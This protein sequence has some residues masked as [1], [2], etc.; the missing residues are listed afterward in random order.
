VLDDEVE[1]TGEGTMPQARAA[2][3]RLE[4]DVV[5]RPDWHN[6]L[7]QISLDIKSQLDKAADDRSRNIILRRLRRALTPEG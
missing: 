4:P 1:L 2:P 6:E 5:G 3:R 7:A